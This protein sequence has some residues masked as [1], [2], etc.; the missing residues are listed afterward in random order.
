[1]ESKPTLG[2]FDEFPPITTQQWEDKIKEDLKGA[3]YQRLIWKTTDGL[4]LKPYYRE[5]DLE[6]LPQLKSGTDIETI[7][8]NIRESNDWEI[9][10]IITEKEPIEANRKAIMALNKG[11]EGLEFCGTSISNFEDLQALLKGVNVSATPLHFNQLENPSQFIQWLKL[12]A[13]D[14]I[15]GSLKFD[16][17][18]YFALYNKWCSTFEAGMQSTADLVNKT[19]ELTSFRVIEVNGFPYNNAGATLVQELAFVLSQGHEYLYRLSQL[20][21]SADAITTKMNFTFGIGSDYFLEIARLRAAR[22]LWAK[23][24]EQYHPEQM[25][26]TTMHIHAITSLGNKTIFDPYVNMLR[27]TT[28]AMAAALGGANRITVSPFD[29]S[30]KKSDEFSERIARNLQHILKHE[31]Y[32]H[33]VADVPG[34]SYYIENL[35]TEIAEAT[36]ALFGAMEEKG[37]FVSCVENGFIQQT[38]EIAAQRRMSDVAQRKQVFVGVNQYPNLDEAMLEKL[39]PTADTTTL[40]NLKPIRATQQLEALRLSVENHKKKGFTAPEVFLLTYGNPTMRKARADFAT[41]FFGCA[42]YTMINNPGFANAL[43]GVPAALQSGAPI[44]VLCSSDEEYN[45]VAQA[46][47]LIKKSAPHTI[48]VLAGYPKEMVEQLAKDGVQFF[49]HLRANLYDALSRFN[50]MLGIV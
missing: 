38:L 20:G 25:Q 33:K 35:T 11:A 8:R 23:I 17:L 31:A 36:W 19:K 50:E 15:K 5:E 2:L 26:R 47:E 41:N 45:Q 14:G 10:Q 7:V 49:I 28:E 21:L 29:A 3:D 48:I 6:N 9:C 4:Q 22:L 27:S 43:D 44:V 34:G 12:A 24:V 16:P 30:F 18:G 40:S 46:I 13:P 37:G 1:M 32:F 42:G 39:Q